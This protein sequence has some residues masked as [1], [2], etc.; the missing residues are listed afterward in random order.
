MR[1]IVSK[2]AVR[3]AL[4]REVRKRGRKSS[5]MT[6][7]P[8]AAKVLGL[9]KNFLCTKKK[10]SE[11]VKIKLRKSVIRKRT[12]ETACS[13]S[14]SKTT[15]PNPI[16]EIRAKIKMGS[17]N[18]GIISSCKPCNYNILVNRNVGRSSNKLVSQNIDSTTTI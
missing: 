10:I 7:G 12:T 16:R 15:N 6:T 8:R 11:S 9:K 5:S 2:A 14:S 4:R 1:K 13:G 17:K 18:L 3:I